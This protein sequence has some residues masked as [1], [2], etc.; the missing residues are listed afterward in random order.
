MIS[1]VF[2][3]QKILEISLEELRVLA[4][5]YNKRLPY[6]VIL[7]TDNERD[8]ARLRRLRIPFKLEWTG[9]WS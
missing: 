9:K 4:K 5:K 7:E 8:I 2:D 6:K 1:L 3:N